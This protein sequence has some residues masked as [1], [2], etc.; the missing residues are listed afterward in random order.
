MTRLGPLQ[1]P[2]NAVHSE[3][4]VKQRHA[5]NRLAW[6]EAAGKY[7]ETNEE[8]L[9]LLRAGNS[10]LHPIERENLKR[11][12]PLANW[13]QRAIHLQC[14]SGQDTLSL[15]LE[16]AKEIVGIDI[17]DV[18]VE[19]ARW[20]AEQLQ[21]PATWICCDVLD[22]PQALNNTA[23]LVY[24]G[25]GAI[26]WIHD[27][28]AWARVVARL[29]KPGGVLSL[30]EDHPAAW[31]FD[32]EAETLTVSQYGYFNSCEASRGW[33]GSYLGNLG[34]PVEEEH[35]KY[36]RLWTPSEVIQALIDTGLSLEYFGEHNQEYWPVF[37]NLNEN[38]RAKLPLTFSLIARKPQ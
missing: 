8:R 2:I 27:I 25:R 13:C 29:L 17:S 33:P 18:H 4:E 30:L 11:I 34:K 24:T 19:N 22:T 20:T 23:D 12:G 37:L 15:I 14:A 7:R 1:H 10:K 32:N 3:Q 28:N 6:N 36:E 16:G 5:E 9:R 31:L 21:F 26:N 38:N 35:I